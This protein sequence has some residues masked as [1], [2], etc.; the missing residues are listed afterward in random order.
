MKVVI[1]DTTTFNEFEQKQ[2]AIDDIIYTLKSD[3][4][5]NEKSYITRVIEKLYELGYYKN[6]ETIYTKEKQ[7]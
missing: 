2:H 3:R 5:I 1:N 7:K 4:Y 6:I